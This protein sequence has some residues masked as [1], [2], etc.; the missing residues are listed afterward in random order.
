MAEDGRPARDD[1]PSAESAELA[2]Q[3]AAHAVEPPL[4]GE[5]ASA[6]APASAG[7]PPSAAAAPRGNVGRGAAL[8]TAGILLSRLVGLVRQRVQAHYFGTGPYADVLTAAFR[9]GNITQ[10][11]LGEGTLS[12]TF[13]PIYAKLHAEGKTAEARKFALAALG[14]LTAVVVIASAAGTLLAPWLSLLIAAGFDE[15]RRE[16]TVSLVRILFPMTGLLVLS[17]WALGVL[18]AHRQFFLPYAAPVLWS[19]A[20]I[21]GLVA[22][23]SFLATSGASL[24]TVLAWSALAGAA[25]QLVILLPA[26]RRWTGSLR[27][28]LDRKDPHVR[29][30]AARLPGAIAGRGIIQISGL[31]DTQLVSF[32]APG[33]TAAFGYA[34]TI[35]LLP[36]ALL[37]T[38]EAAAALPELARDTAEQDPE[39]RKAAMADRIGQSL[40][41]I[42]ALSVPAGLALVFLGH[43][44]VAVLVQTGKFGSEATERVGVLLAAYGVSLLANAAGRILITASYAL[45]DTKTPV[46]YAIY[47]VIVSTLI[48]LALM[49]PLGVLGVVIGAVTAG[50]V[51]TIALGLRLRTAVGG[52][53]LH[54]VRIV[55]AVAAGGL[56]C[57]A[58]VLVRWALPD[59]VASLTLATLPLGPMLALAAFGAVFLVA[60]PAFGLVRVGAL[61]RRR[62]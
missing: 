14:L 44:L 9:L 54:H 2:D 48:A 17:A 42:T 61:L 1:D 16:A 58:G 29:E 46:R 21:A 11:L 41:R 28:S 12:A 53:G 36:M 51:E 22:F 18:N 62:R 59:T 6:H 32:L 50:W 57:G 38:G 30:A 52:L 8:V 34:Q 19:L 5:P 43:E 37:G 20:Q 23:G 39:K 15:A 4:R 7:A 25:L 35:Y 3:I 31:I 56:S 10:N 45:G 24:A 60:A 27:P 40:A 49:K 55:P 13:I 33:D 26:A 47:R